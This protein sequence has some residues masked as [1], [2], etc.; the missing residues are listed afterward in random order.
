MGILISKDDP[1][2]LHYSCWALAFLTDGPN[3]IIQEIVE[4]GLVP[5]LIS[6]LDHNESAVVTPVLKAIRN[7]AAGNEL[8]EIGCVFTGAI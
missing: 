1:E 3:E 7:I 5:R 8:D 2:I 6:L 4:A